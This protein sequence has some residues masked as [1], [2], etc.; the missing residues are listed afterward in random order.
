[1]GN[2]RFQSWKERA[3][4]K[5]AEPETEGA[6]SFLVGGAEWVRFEKK[7]FGGDQ[8]SG[9]NNRTTQREKRKK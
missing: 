7:G 1:M 6:G 4:T 8:M 9:G 2:T 3:D 5:G